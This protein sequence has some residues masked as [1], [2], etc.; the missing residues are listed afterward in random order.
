MHNYKSEEL[1]HKIITTEA[2]PDLND[3]DSDINSFS[4]EEDGLIY[5]G[6]Q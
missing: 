2:D 6:K 4:N 3:S 5:T 1:S